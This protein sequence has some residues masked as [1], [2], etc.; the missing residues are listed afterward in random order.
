MKVYLEHELRANSTLH[1]K[2][3]APYPRRWDA[4]CVGRYAGAY[5]RFII[6]VIPLI[7]EMKK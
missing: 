5:S 3:L 6:V 1:S 4:L 7:C 2:E